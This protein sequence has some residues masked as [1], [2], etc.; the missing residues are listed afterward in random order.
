M[1]QDP[2]VPGT[3]GPDWEDLAPPPDGRSLLG[4][5]RVELPVFEGPLDLLLHLIRKHEIDIFDIPIALI[6]DKYL[7][8]LDWM[9]VLNIDIAAEFLVMAATLA[10]IKSRMLLPPD[11]SAPAE[12]GEEE[13]DPRQDLVRRLLQYQ[14]FK[15]A[16]ESL[17]DRALLDRDVFG[18]G[19]MAAPAA[20]ETS[21]PFAEV[22]VFRLI[23]AL[24]RVL[25]RASLHLTQQIIVERISVADRIQE[26]ADR[27]LQRQEMTFEE[28]FD[29]APDRPAVVVTFVALLEMAR[30]RMIRLHQAEDSDVIYVR[31]LLQ[32]ADM[33][34]AL[35]KVVRD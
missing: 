10:H 29:D 11:E 7:Q 4:D 17:R 2:Q 13:A 14:R 25:K 8:Y 26:L 16:A 31:A 6:T 12:E 20:E 23:E 34:D 24:D 1:S 28:L 9:R 30:L 35:Q 22:S 27:L 3:P 5:Y 21:S 18:R 15:E 19:P 32:A 33:N